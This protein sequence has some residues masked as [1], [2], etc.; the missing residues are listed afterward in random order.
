MEP[1]DRPERTYYRQVSD[2]VDQGVGA[3][4]RQ[5]RAMASRISG[6]KIGRIALLIVC[7][8]TLSLGLAY[9]GDFAVAHYRAAR[10]GNVFDTVNV[11]VFYV[12]QQKSGRTE[13]SYA[14]SQTQ[15]CSRSLFPQLGLTPCWYLRR[16]N[17]KHIEY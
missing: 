14:G 2:I 17:F 8:I 7:G 10:H 12:I 15:T 13:F 16:H 11:D 9:L 3:L 5:R 1:P 6:R 4:P